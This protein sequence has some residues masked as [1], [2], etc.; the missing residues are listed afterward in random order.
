MQSIVAKI[1]GVDRDHAEEYVNDDSIVFL[2]IKRPAIDPQQAVSERLSPWKK[3]LVR[4]IRDTFAHS[5]RGW[6][7]RREPSW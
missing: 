3:G 2:R 1:Q 5:R 6:V 7:L 4:A